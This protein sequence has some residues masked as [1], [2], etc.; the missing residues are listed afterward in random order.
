MFVCFEYAFQYNIMILTDYCMVWYGILY[1]S[2]VVHMTL[3]YNA[4]I[5]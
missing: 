5:M 1:I 4:S 3:V 2:V